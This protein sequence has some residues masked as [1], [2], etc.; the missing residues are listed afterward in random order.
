MLTYSGTAILV[1]DMQAARRFYEELLEQKLKMDVPGYVVYECGLC[2]WDEA[3]AHQSIFQS[4][5][6]LGNPSGPQR[7]EI[8][9]DAD[10][11]DLYAQRLNSAAVP[12]IHPILEMPWGQRVLR[13]YDPDGNVVEIG[14]PMHT[15]V[16]RFLKQ[17]L[18]IEATSQRTSTPLEIVRRIAE[19]LSD[20]VG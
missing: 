16:G 8:F 15:F 3:S 19:A 5:L 14:E 17:G 9:F 1:K 7:F 18:S 2:L 13:V 11:L 20:T 4:P 10:E 6:P 12:V